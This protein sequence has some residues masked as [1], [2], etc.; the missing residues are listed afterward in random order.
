MPLEINGLTPEEYWN[1]FPFRYFRSLHFSGTP[2]NLPELL[3]T[4]A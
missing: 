4:A 3:G 2:E 1:S